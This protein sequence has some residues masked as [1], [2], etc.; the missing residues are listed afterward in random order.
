MRIASA[1]SAAPPS[2]RVRKSARESSH[3]V[4]LDAQ[5]GSDVRFEKAWAD[6]TTGKVF[7]LASGPDK[8]SVKA[9]HKKAGHPTDEIY[10]TSLVVE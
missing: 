6:P 3:Q 8:E 1:S 9:V 2:A 10:E 5:K 7:C 4:D